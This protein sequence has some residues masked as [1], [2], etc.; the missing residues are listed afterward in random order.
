MRAWLYSGAHGGLEKNLK[1]HSDA[2][3]P[4]EHLKQN[5]LHVRVYSMSVNRVDHKIPE[6]GVVSKAVI[7]MPAAPG[8]DFCG[9]VI[10]IGSSV[11]QFKVG[12]VV[13]GKLDKP[14]KFGAL[15]EII[16]A[17][18]SWVAKKPE[19]VAVDDAATIGVTGLTAYQCIAKNV[20]AGD[21]IFI[22]GGSG[23][24][25]V[26]GIQIAKTLGCTVSTS[27]SGANVEFVK[28]LGADEVI[29]YKKQDVAA[30]LKTEGQV[31]SLVVDNIGTPSNLYNESH[32]FLQPHGK[33]VQVG[34]EPSVGAAASLASRMLLPGILGGGKRKF[35]FL[36]AFSKQ[37]DFNQIAAWMAEGK[38]KAV[39]EQTFEF[40]DAPKAYEKLKEGRTRGKIV[41]HV[42]KP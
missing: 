18:Q 14:S 29:D 4:P 30:A 3:Q 28:S 16:V 17:D 6:L 10:S 23:G 26:Y 12:D 40:E 33:F 41:V 22:N 42:S 34:A 13:F 5:Q 38:V 9:E 8:M 24:T 39:I 27:C 35:E 31:Y 36:N 1:L 20:K 11:T 7:S 21:K 15:G 37:D 19:S 32:H 2:P 25:G